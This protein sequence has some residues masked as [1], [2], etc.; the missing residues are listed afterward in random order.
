MRSFTIKP[1][2]RPTKI[3]ENSALIFFP[4][5]QQFNFRFWRNTVMHQKLISRLLPAACGLSRISYAYLTW[6]AMW[7]RFFRQRAFIGITRSC[8][9]WYVRKNYLTWVHRY[10]TVFWLQ[11]IFGWSCL[12]SRFFYG[13]GEGWFRKRVKKYFFSNLYPNKI[14]CINTTKH[15]CLCL[16]YRKPCKLY[17]YT[18]KY[19]LKRWKLFGKAKIAFSRSNWENPKIHLI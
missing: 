6:V 10:H 9:H 11:V 8:M 5:W 2:W 17:Y 1:S 14:Y 4:D 18:T 3:A 12:G 19:G 13:G 16:E 15:S 7:D